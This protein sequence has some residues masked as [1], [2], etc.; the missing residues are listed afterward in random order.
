[1]HKLTAALTKGLAIFTLDMKNTFNSISRADMVAAVKE[2][3]PALVLVV[4][5]A[6]GEV[7]SLRVMGAPEST[8]HIQSQW[9][10]RQRGPLVPPM[11]ALTL[12]LVLEHA[13]AGA[14][15]GGCG[16]RQPPPHVA[17]LDDVCIAGTPPAG[18]ATFRRLLDIQK[19]L[20]SIGQELNISKLRSPWPYATRRK[21][22]LWRWNSGSGTCIRV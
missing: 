21:S 9:G 12:Q 20:Q 3:A 13:E 7:T 4:Q 19:R 8:A 15:V 14:A 17:Y 11:F 10:V 18:A 1:M 5:W 16:G 6:H 2:R 22:P